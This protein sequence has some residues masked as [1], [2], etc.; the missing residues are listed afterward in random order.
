MS[1]IDVLID[2]EGNSIEQGYST[3]RAH[4]ELGCE[5]ANLYL[6][7]GKNTIRLRFDTW[8]EMI[9][10][11]EKHNFSYKDERPMKPAEAQEE[12]AA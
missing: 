4:P 9:D 11:C 1:N 5:M 2:T 6:K 7:C 12:T 3:L 10:F 8:Q